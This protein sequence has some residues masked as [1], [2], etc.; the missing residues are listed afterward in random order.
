M[1][2]KLA[3]VLAL[4]AS[5]SAQPWEI[6]QIRSNQKDYNS[7]DMSM[8]FGTIVVVNATG[9]K[10][11]RIGGKWPWRWQSQVDA[12]GKPRPCVSTPE[13]SMCTWYTTSW[14][15]ENLTVTVS[16]DRDQEI[17]LQMVEFDSGRIPGIHLPIPKELR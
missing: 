16:S 10:D 15:G 12:Y 13:V 3:I 11:M 2:I 17:Q 5:C 1:A 6:V 8:I 14:P 4:A 7:I 9:S